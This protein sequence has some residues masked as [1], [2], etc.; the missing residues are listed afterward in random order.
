MRS[1]LQNKELLIIEICKATNN[2]TKFD[3]SSEMTKWV[4]RVDSLNRPLNANPNILWTQCEIED[5]KYFI[6]RQEW[7]IVIY[8]TTVEYTQAFKQAGKC[9]FI[10]INIKPDYLTH[11]GYTQ[12]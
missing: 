9:A 11:N 10:I 12:Y 7:D 1:E 6:Y 2:F 4:P 5:K 8:E 3:G